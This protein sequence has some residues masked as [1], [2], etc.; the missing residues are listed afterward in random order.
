VVK[1][2]G[3]KEFLE[4]MRDLYE[5]VIFTASLSLYADPLLDMI[6][7]SGCA[8]YRLF[9]DHCTLCN[10]TFVKDLSIL[11]RDLKDVLIVDNSP[12][13]YMFQPEN[14]MPIVTW[15]DDQKDTKLFEL[16]IVL[17]LMVNVEDVREVIKATVRNDSVDYLKLADYLQTELNCK[18]IPRS[19]SHAESK[20]KQENHDPRSIPRANS[21]ESRKKA[22]NKKDG[23]SLKKAMKKGTPDNVEE[24]SLKRQASSSKRRKK[25]GTPTPYSGFGFGK[26]S[27]TGKHGLKLNGKM[28]SLHKPYID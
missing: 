18:A 28:L 17:E 21:D 26:G 8:T 12:T 7:P 22:L 16:A 25:C 5:I 13:A 3:V 9:R 10:N 20:V 2:P 1:R 15:I 14:A 27:L 23:T 4:R 11:G 24:V 6:D 19:N